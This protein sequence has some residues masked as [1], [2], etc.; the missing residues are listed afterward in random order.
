M[1]MKQIICELRIWSQMKNDPRSYVRNFYNCVKKPERFIPDIWNAT[2]KNKRCSQMIWKKNTLLSSF[3][4]F[5]E[6]VTVQ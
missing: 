5:Y 4:K 3:A 2:E 6:Y 1:Y